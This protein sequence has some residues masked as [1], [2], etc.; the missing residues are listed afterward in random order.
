[1]TWVAGTDILT[2]SLVTSAQWNNYLGTSG[3]LQY[4]QYTTQTAPTRAINGTVY[5]NTNNK[6]RLI[7]VSIECSVS[8]GGTTSYGSSYFIVYCD[9]NA[10][11]ST[12]IT[13]G[14]IYDMGISI[15]SGSAR[16]T[17]DFI[18]SFVALPS[19][20]YKIT[21]GT[22]NNGVTPTKLYWYE[23]D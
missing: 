13:R 17:E 8:S 10:L 12:D 3:S 15:A 18:V 1:M 14:G 9:S 20:Y 16:S 23:W 5:Q 6:I 22:T 21:T 7:S 11:P 19:Y 4:L 2:G